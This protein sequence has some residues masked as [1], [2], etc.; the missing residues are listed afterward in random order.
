[1]LAFTWKASNTPG[2]YYLLHH[3]LKQCVFGK[4]IE[5]KHSLQYINYYV[6]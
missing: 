2:D 5:V 3:F 1:M 6:L 4:I